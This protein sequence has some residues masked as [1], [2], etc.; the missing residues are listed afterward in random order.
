MRELWAYRMAT[1]ARQGA[2]RRVASAGTA[3]LLVF[4]ISSAA[5]ARQIVDMAGR[6]VTIPDVISKAVAVSPP[7]TYLLYAIDPGLVAGLNFPLWE[8]EKKY[9]IPE[10]RRL[11]V[12]GGLAGQS[13]TMNR[14]VLLQ[15]APDFIVNWTWKDDAINRK[16]V[17]SLALLPFPVIN[18]HI[19]SIT[20]YPA[21]LRF[22]GDITGRKSRS[23]EL[24]AYADDILNTA[25][26]TV[27]KIPQT[28]K[29][30][31]YYAE[32]IDGLATERENSLHAEL[33][34]LAGGINV[35]KGEEVDH[36]GME[37]ISMEQVLLYDPDVILVKEKTFFDRLA[38]DERWQN[39]RA[40]RNGRVYWIPAEPFNW[41]DRPPSFMRL[42]GIEWLLNVLHPEH[43]PV[44]LVQKTRKFYELFLGVHLDDAEAR[45]VL[46]R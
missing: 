21:A 41:F 26:A 2:G 9:T 27:S 19:G 14:E 22:V 34:P 28:E 46:G 37:K 13:R 32:G 10:Y 35:H 16:F 29:V 4:F 8:S 11:P 44:D 40:V 6:Q 36:L 39:L 30:S 17:E 5:V 24:A 7:G 33:I 15:V 43:Y 42:L 45:E 3:M 20:D 23:E 38:S 12:I 31:I 25:A 18:V 1:A